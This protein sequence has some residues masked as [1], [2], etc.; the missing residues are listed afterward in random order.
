MKEYEKL[1]EEYVCE[2][3]LYAEEERQAFLAGFITCREMA[4]NECPEFHI[5]LI[6][7]TLGEKEVYQRHKTESG[8]E[9]VTIEDNVIDQSIL[10][11]NEDITNKRKISADNYIKEPPTDFREFVGFLEECKIV[12][13][14]HDRYKVAL[15]KILDLDIGRLA[16]A[17]QIAKVALDSEF[18]PGSLWYKEAEKNSTNALSRKEYGVPYMSGVENRIFQD[19]YK[20]QT[21][22][23][24]SHPCMLGVEDIGDAS[25][26]ILFVHGSYEATKVCQNIILQRHRYRDALQIISNINSSADREL[27]LIARNAL[28]E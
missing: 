17:Y 20:E 18:N 24:C 4:L 27:R 14:E 23:C 9:Y 8:A 7:K 22:E 3:D 12:T 5:Q 10:N 16:L 26:N 21:L 11:K 13:K 2:M 19:T 25:G 15:E 6:L 28:D 1:A